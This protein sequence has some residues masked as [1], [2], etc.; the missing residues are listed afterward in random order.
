MLTGLCALVADDE[1]GSQISVLDADDYDTNDMDAY[2][3]YF[4]SDDDQATDGAMK[5]GNTTIS[6]DGDSYNFLFKKNGGAES[7]GR[8]IN[9]IEDGKYIYQYGLR[10]KA[11]SDERYIAVLA[12]GD[13]GDDEAKVVDYDSSDIRNRS[14][15]DANLQ[16]NTFRNKDGDTVRVVYNF[17][18]D[19]YLVN[20][21]GRIQDGK[22]TGVK[23]GDEWYWYTNSDGEIILYTNNKELDTDEDDD[24]A[25]GLED[26]WD[27]LTDTVDSNSEITESASSKI[28]SFWN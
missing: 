3:Y 6:L 22:K 13:S 26:G 19:W 25:S 7:R 8:G 10:I 28:A 14:I 27:Q 2:L 5:T 11:D 17:P 9:G 20:T 12:T 18:T 1:D 24:V 15:G 21:S 23:D 16:L 4:G